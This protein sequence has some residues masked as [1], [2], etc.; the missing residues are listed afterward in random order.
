MFKFPVH[1]EL[2]YS[3]QKDLARDFLDLAVPIMKDHPDIFRTLKL[4]VG[5]SLGLTFQPY[6]VFDAPTGQIEL[7]DVP[8]IPG[9]LAEGGQATSDDIDAIVSYLI[10]TREG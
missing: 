3:V 1:D 7:S 5:V 8:A 2:V 6:H 10:E 9:V 4:D